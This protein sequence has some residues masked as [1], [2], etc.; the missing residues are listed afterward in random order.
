MVSACCSEGVNFE[1]RPAGYAGISPG[2]M[3]EQGF[4]AGVQTVQRPNL[5]V[6]KDQTE[7]NMWLEHSV[8]D[9][10]MRVD[11]YVGASSHG[12]ILK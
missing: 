5:R 4:Q 7:K 8:R 10:M 9:G 1:L 12:T 2:E 11:R 3:E 6:F